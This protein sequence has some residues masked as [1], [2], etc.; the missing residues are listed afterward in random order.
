MD[1][2][3]IGNIIKDI[4]Q[5]NNLTQKELADK[6]NVTYQ[7]VSKWENGRNIPDIEILKEISLLFG[8]DISLLL[9]M[10]KHENKKLT[11]FKKIMFVAL[12]GLIFL[13]VFL[14]FK[15]DDFS[16]K[17]IGSSCSSFDIVGSI[18]FNKDKSSI[19]ISN[20]EYCGEDDNNKKYDFITCN[21]YEKFNNKNIL[22]SECDKK[23]NITLDE[24]LDNLNINVSD[25]KN[26]CDLYKENDM[27]IEI[28]AISKDGTNKFIIPLEFK[29]NCLD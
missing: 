19:Y 25:Y 5:K 27:F 3:K 8:I 22:I 26:S 21:L 7:A 12:I 17:K 4:R 11:L 1:Q 28:N 15:K 10:E 6:L 2:Q 23:D 24:Y 20:I 9:D 16:F 13:V 29:D 18:A 14:I